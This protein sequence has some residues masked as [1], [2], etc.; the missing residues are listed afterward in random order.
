MSAYARAIPAACALLAATASAET[1]LSAVSLRESCRAYAIAPESDAAAVCAGYVSGYL[2][3]ARLGADVR[4]PPASNASSPETFAERATRTRLGTH[5]LEALRQR[6][7]RYCLD[8]SVAAAEIIE[9]LLE[10]L[11]AHPPDDDTLAADALSTALRLN[12]PCET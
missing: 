10:Y 4:S 6:A 1:S 8:E 7:H 11:R 2:D 9:R 5:N 12:Y 3:S